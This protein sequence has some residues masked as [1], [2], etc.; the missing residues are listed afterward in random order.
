MTSFGE[1]HGAAVGGIVDGCPA[2]MALSVERVQRE[3]DW[4]RPGQSALTTARREPDRV[5][6]LS[7]LF[8][9][10][11]TGAPIGFLVR[12]QD[13]RPDDYAELRELYRPSHADYT[14]E[15][16]YGLRD[17]RG[18]GR[19]SAREHVARVVAG[20]IAR[21][22]L[23][24]LGVTIRAYVS[25]VGGVSL[26]GDVSRS[27]LE[28][29]DE[30]PV[31]C[32]DA[33]T[34]RLMADEIARARE[35]GDNGGGVVSCLVRGVPVGLGEPVFD[36]FQARLAYYMMGINAAKG[37]EYGE[38]FRAAGLRGSEHNDEM[39]ADEQGRPRFKTNHAG[40]I[41]GGVTTG[42][43]ICFRVAFKPVSTIGRT[44]QTVGRDGRAAVFFA[45]GRHDACVAP[46]AVPVVEAMTAMLL[47]D[48]LLEARRWD[49]C[50]RREK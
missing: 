24:P 48:A 14:W 30:N 29:V 22:A 6:I 38:G 33:A 34:A 12:N 15:R 17:Y 16:K 23:E 21:Q 3:L 11:T 47:L 27:A 50:P 45:T 1:S 28:A 4:R 42:E 31:R 44:Q 20:A 2:G 41:L 43:D 49:V 13:Q 40:G 46:R 5:E 39:F 37:F 35:E 8:E 36:R 32:P 25:R 19:A 7:G 9:G 18:G 10:R 26:E